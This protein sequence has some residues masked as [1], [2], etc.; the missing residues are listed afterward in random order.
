MYAQ[1]LTRG[2]AAMREHW[3]T[4]HAWRFAEWVGVFQQGGT[5]HSADRQP[6]HIHCHGGNPTLRFAKPQKIAI[7][8]CRVTLAGAAVTGA[9]GWQPS[10]DPIQNAC[11]ATRKREAR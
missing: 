1:R 11:W 9:G 7:A 10:F 8:A 5:G 2:Q 3:A 6:A 4:P